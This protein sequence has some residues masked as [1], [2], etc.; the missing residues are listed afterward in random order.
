[1]PP[2]S[3]AVST[4]CPLWSLTVNPENLAIR[5]FDERQSNLL[6]RPFRSDI[7]R[8]RFHQAQLKVALETLRLAADVR[9]AYFRA[10]AANEM[11]GLL[12]DAKST[13]EDHP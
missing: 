5:S 6:R 13:A 3:G 1:M 11:V 2:W 9:R 8:D 10:V 4:R 12:T 7:A